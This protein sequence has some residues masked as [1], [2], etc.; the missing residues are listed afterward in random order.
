M[1]VLGGGVDVGGRIRERRLVRGWSVRF[2]ASRAGVSHASWSRIERGV[3]AADNR[4]MV[5]A[6]AKALECAPEDLVGAGVPAPDR[7]TAAA[8]AGVVGLRTALIDI[9]LSEPAVGAAP[10]VSELGRS[11]ALGRCA[12]PGV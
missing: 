5:A 1:R 4:F 6:I 2:A 8:R 11:V 3:Q 10:S 7:V 12:A 9:D